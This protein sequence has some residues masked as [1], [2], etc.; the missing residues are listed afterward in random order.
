MRA[1]LLGAV[2]G[3]LALSR[4]RLPRPKYGLLRSL[5]LHSGLGSL[6]QEYHSFE[7]IEEARLAEITRGPPRSPE[8]ARD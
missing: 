1:L 3:L 7:L 2:G 4:T 5:L 6:L 8:V